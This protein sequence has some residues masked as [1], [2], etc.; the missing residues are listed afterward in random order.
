M[1]LLVRALNRLQL[2]SARLDLSFIGFVG[3]E[4]LSIQARVHVGAGS[5]VLESAFLVRKI[6][7]DQNERDE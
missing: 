5:R 4:L 6:H 1:A 7:K 2:R 3:L